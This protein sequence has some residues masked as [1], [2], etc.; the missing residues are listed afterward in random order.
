MAGAIDLE[1]TEGDVM[2]VYHIEW[3]KGVIMWITRE[4]VNLEPDKESLCEDMEPI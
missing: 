3:G 4:A 2:Y 1:A